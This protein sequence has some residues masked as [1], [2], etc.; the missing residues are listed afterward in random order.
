MSD[1]SSDGSAVGDP[2]SGD[3]PPRGL[4]RGEVDAIVATSDPVLRNLQITQGYHELALALSH[5]L[6]QSPGANWYAFA[7]WASKQAGHTI[8]GEDPWRVAERELTLAPEVT[9]ALRAMVVA[10][11]G[12]G[13]R[14]EMEGLRSLLPRVLDLEGAQ[15]R[16][17]DALARG[18]ARVFQEM[19][20]AAAD[21]LQAETDPESGAFLS[22]LDSFR[23]G[24]P[25]DGQTYLRRAFTRFRALRTPPGPPHPSEQLLLANLEIGVHEQ[26]RLQPELAEAVNSVLPDPEAFRARFLAHLLPGGW[27]RARIRFWRIL[28]RTSPLDQAVDTLAL[29]IRR[30]FRRQLTRRVMT[31]DLAGAVTLRLGEDIPGPFPDRLTHLEV[32][33]LR[34]LLGR[35]GALGGAGEGG[36]VAGTAGS[37][38]RDW[39]VLDQRLRFIAH[40]FRR[41]QEMPGLLAPPFT[42]A[43]AQEIRAGRRPRGRL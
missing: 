18:N 17:V 26:I 32:S 21:F 43:Q 8:R 22:F 7:V 24:D 4:S 25:P 28:G 3:A 19:G 5:R 6:V 37:G 20:G 13:V 40:L 9:G 11:R 10:A 27:A 29:A 39:E 42:T 35:Y 15:A 2:R 31:M 41:Y 36:G 23:N 12:L 14:V 33:E 30:A 34:T 1:G 16:S 38:A